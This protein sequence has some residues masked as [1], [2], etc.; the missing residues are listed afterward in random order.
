[1]METTKNPKILIVDDEEKNHRL[2]TAI[3]KNLSCDFQTARD[4]RE[5]ILKTASFAPDLIFLDIM[6]PE[7]DGFAVCRILKDN[8]ETRT[9]PIV[10][11][12]A[13]D[14][15]S[16]KLKALEAGAND[17]LT[18]PVDGTEVIFRTRNLLRIKQFEDFLKD[19]AAR[20][21]AETAKKTA[22]LSLAMQ[23]LVRSQKSLK[24]S[25]LDTIYR[26]TIVAEYKD[27]ASHS[28]VKRVGLCCA[29]IAAQLG[30]SEE[31]V[32]LIKYASPMHD[33]GKIGIPSDILLKPATLTPEELALVKTHTTI[34]GKIL[35]GSHSAF[36]Q[37]AE[38][39]AINH[40][41]RWDGTGYPAGLKGEEI[42]IEGRIV[43]FAD[44]YDALRSMRPYKP[45]FD[46]VMAYR[47]ML[48][49]NERMGPRHFDPKLLEV[50]KDTHK[51]IEKIYDEYQDIPASMM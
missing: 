34:G 15:K 7:M 24:A 9:I 47:I 17:F 41:E 22:Q 29:H 21:E 39:I 46:Y 23:G 31:R 25:Y 37:M 42:P 49:G 35:H 28:H 3:L 6:L 48:E 32:E 14:D 8:P 36:L 44:Q 11:V 40:H 5:A 26:L 13:L 38:T 10:M 19:H 33:I 12:T 1:M 16:S 2:M 27:E 51:A 43:A 45:P 4:G 30:W 18:K 50:F 20:L